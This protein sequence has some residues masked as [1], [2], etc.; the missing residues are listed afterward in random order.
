CDWLTE[1]E[2]VV[3]V[4]QFVSVPVGTLLKEFEIRLVM[5]D[6]VFVNRGGGFYVAR[7]SYRPTDHVH[8]VAVFLVEVGFHLRAKIQAMPLVVTAN[9]QPRIHLFIVMWLDS[10]DLAL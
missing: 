4:S 2:L 5:L 3:F 7:H 10:D 8:D 6:H 9:R 1:L